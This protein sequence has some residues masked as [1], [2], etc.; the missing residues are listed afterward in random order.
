MFDDNSSAP[1]DNNNAAA[2]NYSTSSFQQPVQ[3]NEPEELIP[4]TFPNENPAGDNSGQPSDQ[5]Y[6]SNNFGSRVPEPVNPPPADDTNNDGLL[7]IKQQALQQLSP[8]VDNLEQSPEDKFRTTMMMIQA[9]DNQSLLKTAFE[10]AQKIT[11]DKARAQA[12]LDVV[13]EINYFTQQ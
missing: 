9:S 6:P 8:L 11:D 7:E 5:P 3:Q 10:S 13:N 12:L 2:V 4:A 1:A